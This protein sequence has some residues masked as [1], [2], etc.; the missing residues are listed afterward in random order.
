MR[1]VYLGGKMIQ[2]K[3][4]FINENTFI[5]TK[6]QELKISYP[7]LEIKIGDIE[8]KIEQ[9]YIKEYFLDRKTSLIH[10]EIFER[11]QDKVNNTS[12]EFKKPFLEIAKNY[13]YSK[14]ERELIVKLQNNDLLDFKSNTLSLKDENFEIY[15]SDKDR[16]VLNFI[17]QH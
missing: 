16:F 9:N 4:K 7:I 8:L 3:S 12:S 2:F 13:F 5:S 1:L 6:P 17:V 10:C 11:Y 14:D 15:F